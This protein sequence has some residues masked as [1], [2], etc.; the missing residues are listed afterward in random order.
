[1]KRLEKMKFDS[2]IVKWENKLIKN[3]ESSPNPRY[4]AV[5]DNDVAM[6]LFAIPKNEIYFIFS[7][8]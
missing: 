7:V 3:K 8:D 4:K 1:M 5:I 2:N 6:N